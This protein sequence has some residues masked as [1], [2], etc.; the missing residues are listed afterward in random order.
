[1][2]KVHGS[3]IPK[4]LRTYNSRWKRLCSQ[5]ISSSISELASLRSLP[6]GIREYSL[7]AWLFCLSRLNPLPPVFWWKECSTFELLSSLS[8]P[9]RWVQF[10]LKPECRIW[11]R[12][13]QMEFHHCHWCR[14][15]RYVRFWCPLKCDSQEVEGLFRQIF[16]IPWSDIRRLHKE[17]GREALPLRAT[18][19]GCGSAC[20]KDWQFR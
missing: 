16:C 18:Y 7:I 11:L 10:P 17:P 1:M 13:L 4:Q 19:S 2:F 6:I 9:L 15:P 8:F 14:C 3:V 12:P 20:L 5:S